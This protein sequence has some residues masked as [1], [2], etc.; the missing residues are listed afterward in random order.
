MAR[1]WQLSWFNKQ[2]TQTDSIGPKNG[3]ITRGGETSPAERHHATRRSSN[4]L[5]V[6]RRCSGRSLPFKS[7]S[8]ITPVVSPGKSGKPERIITGTDGF[9]SFSSA[10]TAVPFMPDIQ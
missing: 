9:N 1:D 5:I 10:A 2:G 7:H 4:A 3:K 8:S 6:I